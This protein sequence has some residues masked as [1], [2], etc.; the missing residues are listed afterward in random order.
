MSKME[1]GALAILVPLCY[2]VTHEWAIGLA[3][4]SV[5]VLGSTPCTVYPI[6]AGHA[7]LLNDGRCSRHQVPLGRSL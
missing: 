1:K 3:G 2:D 7:L 4:R 5:W 6:S